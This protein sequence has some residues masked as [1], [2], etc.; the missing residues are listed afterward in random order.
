M[1]RRA[2]SDHRET[3]TPPSDKSPDLDAL[4]MYVSPLPQEQHSMQETQRE[5]AVLDQYLDFLRYSPQ[6]IEQRLEPVDQPH[7]SFHGQSPTSGPQ[8]VPSHQAAS[9]A[10]ELG[11]EAKYHQIVEQLLHPQ[12]GKRIPR[13]TQEEYEKILALLDQ[14]KFEGA[15]DE[16][17]VKRAKR[18]LKKNLSNIKLYE[19]KREVILA[20]QAEY[21]QNNK[22]TIRAKK[23][24]YC[25]NNRET[26]L[27]QQ[28]EHYQN[29]RETKL[30]QQAEHYQNNKEA[31]LAQQA[32]YRK[33]HKE[34]ILA[35]QAQ[36][37][38]NNRETRLAQRAQYY[39]NNRETRLAQRAQYYQNNRE[40]IRAQQAQCRERLR[41]PENLVAFLERTLKKAQDQYGKKIASLQQHIN[42]LRDQQHLFHDADHAIPQKQLLAEKQTL[43]EQTRHKWN[44]VR[45]GKEKALGEARHLVQI[46]H[47]ITAL[48]QH[49]HSPTHQHDISFEPLP[50]RQEPS[51]SD[52]AQEMRAFEENYHEWQTTV[53]ASQDAQKLSEFE[54]LCTEYRELQRHFEEE[55]EP[56]LAEFVDFEYSN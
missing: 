22:E 14:K 35:R 7:Q 39:Q 24:Q 13:F 19:T 34:A 45:E 48:V 54:G 17:S 41:I 1:K 56:L 4:R 5:S 46:Q 18:K 8:E 51:S 50:L 16:L 20:Q 6:E 26:R 53:Q 10:S 12:K 42:A 23:A 25:K 52:A 2:E 37:R 15:I 29:N 47:E 28:A 27:A 21:Y 33:N 43:L 36:C 3:N 30:A 38:K 40:T 11:D 49:P 9:S 31:I 44:E 55:L 32:Q